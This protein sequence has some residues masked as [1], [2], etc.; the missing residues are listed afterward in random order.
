MPA[1]LSI[2]QK[3]LDGLELR[4]MPVAEFAKVAGLENIRGASKTVLNESFRD[5]RPLKNDSAEQC[6][7]LW[8]EIDA[9]C[10]EFEPFALSLKDGVRVHG[11]LVARRKGEIF[12]IV[13]DGIAKAEEIAEE[14]D[15]QQV[16]Q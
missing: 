9:M 12:H 5:I 4:Q 1:K 11:W 8:V 2:D 6:W 10:R 13:V 7:A 3:L 15:T 14:R 16:E